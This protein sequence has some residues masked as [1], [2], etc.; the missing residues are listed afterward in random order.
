MQTENVQ[1]I[2]LNISIVVNFLMKM[3]C[4]Q[5]EQE[6]MYVRNAVKYGLKKNIKSIRR[7]KIIS[8]KYCQGYNTILTESLAS[9]FYVTY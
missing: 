7:K 1:N 4:L 5:Q 3:V 6:I 2:T 8:R 9:Y